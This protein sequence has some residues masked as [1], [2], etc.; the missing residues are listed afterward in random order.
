M[1]ERGRLP[2]RSGVTNLALLR[3]P[4]RHVIRIR[5]PLEIP[6]VARNARGRCEIEVAIRVALITLQLRVST[7]QGETNRIMIEAGGLPGRGRMAILAGLRKSERH[8]IRAAGFL[9]IQ[10]V[11]ADASSRGARVFAS[12]VAS[13]AIQSCVHAC[14]SEARNFCVIEFHALPVTDR[15][16]VLA[17]RRKSCRYVVWRSSLLERSLMTGITL[18]R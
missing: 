15:V 1:V 16:T 4:G 18:Y 12:R 9:K 3:N 13:R 14:K 2:G 7:G 17:L 11:A 10:Q 5:R 6:Q 8:V